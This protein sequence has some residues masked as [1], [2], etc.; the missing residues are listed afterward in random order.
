LCLNDVDANIMFE[1]EQSIGHA[2]ENNAAPAGGGGL[3]LWTKRTP[4]ISVLCAPGYEGSWS[5][6]VPCSIGSYKNTSGTHLCELCLP[7]SYST[8]LASSSCWQCDIDTF[9]TDLGATSSSTCM[10]CPRDS[11]TLDV[12]S[13]SLGHCICVA[14]FVAHSDGTCV[15]CDAGKFKD[16]KGTQPCTACPAGTYANVPAATFCKPCPAGS[17]T[18]PGATNRFGCFCSPGSS[19]PSEGPCISCEAG[20]YGLGGEEPCQ[21]CAPGT[22]SI[23]VLTAVCAQCEV[24]YYQASSGMTTCAVCPTGRQTNGQGSS[25]IHDCVCGPGYQTEQDSVETLNVITYYSNGGYAT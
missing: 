3:I 20:S 18:L 17:T 10:S 25:V 12:G 7:G 21:E 11:S 8:A 15:F 2:A 16:S 22:F 24:G 4:K 5:E 1:V 19:G 6:C 23:S 14:G 9:S 13:P